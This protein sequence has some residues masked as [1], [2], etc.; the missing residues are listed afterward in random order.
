MPF[1][2]KKAQ[3]ALQHFPI[4]SLK[5]YIT[6]IPA[7]I[8]Y[9]EFSSSAKTYKIFANNGITGIKGWCIKNVLFF[10]IMLVQ[11]KSSILI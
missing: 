9:K 7:V 5:Y 11:I 2:N 6:I 4:D 3:G 10:L 8:I 1:L